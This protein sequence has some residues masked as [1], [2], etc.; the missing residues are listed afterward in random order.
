MFVLI[1][2]VGTKTNR[3]YFVLVALFRFYMNKKM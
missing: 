3:D 2:S 1:V